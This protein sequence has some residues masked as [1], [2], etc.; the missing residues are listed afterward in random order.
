MKTYKTFIRLVSKPSFLLIVYL[1][2]SIGAGLQTAF[3][4]MLSPYREGSYDFIRNSSMNNYAIYQGSFF[5][6]LQHKFLYGYHW[7]EHYDLYLYSPSFPFVIMP[8]A[9]L[10]KYIGVVVWCVFNALVLF[11][12][13]RWL[14]IDEKK[15][16]IIHWFVLVELITAIQNV[17]V[18]PLVAAL[19]VLTFIA[20]ERKQVGLAALFI[21]SSMFIK[22]FGIVGAAFFILYPKRLKFFGYLFL[23]SSLIFLS[24]LIFISRDEL[25]KQYLGWYT[26][27]ITL[28]SEN[29]GDLSA[30]QLLASLFQFTLSDL[31]RYTIQATAVILFCLK[32]IRY[33]SFTHPQFKLLFLASI[34]VWT[35][36]FNNAVESPSFI[37][38]ITGVAIWYI[39]DEKSKMNLGLLI[40]ALVITSLSHSDLFPRYI[41]DNFIDP[42]AL[43]CLPCF[44]IWLKIEFE[45]LF[46][47]RSLVQPLHA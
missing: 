13:V 2:I 12:A 5:H 17:Q 46:R 3:A 34:L 38:A 6:L 45:L 41:R 24:P 15:K 40:F 14:K 43:K 42:Y 27:I 25:I 19:F 10:Q 21:A 20:F 18:N 22:I 35:T 23:W 28:H 33:H 9:L 32:Y 30:M 8:F 39:A 36:I 31:G 11:Y 29:I 7:S 44:I 4:D 37:I 26:T 1:V 47:K 16:V